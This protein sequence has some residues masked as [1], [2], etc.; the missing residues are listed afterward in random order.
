MSHAVKNRLSPSKHPLKGVLVILFLCAVQCLIPT[1]LIATAL[2]E[3]AVAPHHGSDS[4]KRAQSGRAVSPNAYRSRPEP[5]VQI[6]RLEPEVAV[7][8]TTN[9]PRIAPGPSAGQGLEASISSRSYELTSDSV[10]TS[11]PA[12]APDRKTRRY[13]LLSWPRSSSLAHT[14][15]DE[16]NRRSAIFGSSELTIAD[17]RTPASG[18]RENFNPLLEIHLVVFKL[19]VSSM[20]RTLRLA[21]RAGEKWERRRSCVW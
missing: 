15:A 19:P 3:D 5:G 10:S 12:T 20:H 13:S 7:G 16:V 6:S 11:Y 9:R 4:V 14:E 18:P 21:G 2:A 17:T 8:T 1:F